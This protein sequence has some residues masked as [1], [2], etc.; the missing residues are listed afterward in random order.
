[1]KWTIH[2]YF[3]PAMKWLFLWKLYFLQFLSSPSL[4]VKQLISNAKI[5][6][7]FLIMPTKLK[8]WESH[9]LV[10][11]KTLIFPPPF[12]F[13]QNSIVSLWYG[14]TRNTSKDQL[15]V[16]NGPMARSKTK[17]LNAFVFKVSTKLD[18]KS[19]LEYQENF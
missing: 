15:Y 4:W 14:P 16:P 10:M 6:I 1:M 9:D 17:A 5:Q 18:L 13:L 3:C 11:Q 19:P 12:Q 2:K 8:L 7:E